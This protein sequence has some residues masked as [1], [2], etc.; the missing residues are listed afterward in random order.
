MNST[1]GPPITQDFLDEYN[2]G[3]LQAVCISFIIIDT[4]FVAM[5]YLS[6][7]YQKAPFAWDDVLIV[8]AWVNLLGVSIDGIRKSNA[9]LAYRV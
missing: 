4:F 2:G 1:L 6:R 7:R 3:Q 5:R 8:V 9:F